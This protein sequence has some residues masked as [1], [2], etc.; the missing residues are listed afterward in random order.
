MT[1]FFDSSVL[2]AAM[3]ED[4]PRHEASLRA[5]AGAQAGCASVHSLFE[6]YAA[7]TGGRL[8]TRLTPTDAAGMI[9]ANLQDRLKLVSLTP[10]EQMEVVVSAGAV[11]A[12]GGAVYDLLVLGAARKAHADRILTLNLR[13]F[14]AFAPDLTD[15]IT[16]P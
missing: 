12:R 1:L 4:E 8:G 5:L 6:C 9:R 11:G 15:R 10:G 13:H 14:M 16:E 7:L 2:V 3:V